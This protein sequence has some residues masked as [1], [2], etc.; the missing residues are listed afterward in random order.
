MNIIGEF[1]VRLL[2]CKNKKKFNFEAE[3]RT[4]SKEHGLIEN[5]MRDIYRNGEQIIEIYETLTNEKLEL[6]EYKRPAADELN[7]L[8]DVFLE[9]Y[10][11]QLAQVNN[12]AAYQGRKGEQLHLH[13]TSF[14]YSKT[15]LFVGYFETF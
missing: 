12:K 5:A 8:L 1:F 11:R 3:V 7:L 9:C 14:L 2:Q 6:K 13:P 10:P 4:F 15:P